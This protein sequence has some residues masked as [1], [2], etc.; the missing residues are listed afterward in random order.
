MHRD[1]W[2]GLTESYEEALTHYEK[3]EFRRA[4]RILGELLAH[5]IH[6]DDGPTL[7]L[8]QRAVTNLVDAPKPFNPVWKLADKGK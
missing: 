5:R 8:M 2:S 1:D 3:Q 4:A 6:R 7:V